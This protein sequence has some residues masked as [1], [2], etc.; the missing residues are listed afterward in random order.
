VLGG[1]RGLGGA[2]E[3]RRK[4]GRE[5]TS[6]GDFTRKGTRVGDNV[7]RTKVMGDRS[8]VV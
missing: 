4:T 6:G 7:G 2:F 5:S 1:E 8:V 3:S